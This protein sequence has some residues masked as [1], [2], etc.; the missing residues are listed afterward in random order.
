MMKQIFKDV[1]LPD[2][3][4]TFQGCK[5]IKAQFSTEGNYNKIMQNTNDSILKHI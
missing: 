3:M 1:Y 4:L 5:N 2:T